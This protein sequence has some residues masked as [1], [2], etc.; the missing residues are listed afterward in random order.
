VAK[1]NHFAAKRG[2]MEEIERRRTEALARSRRG[3]REGE[4]R[5]PRLSLRVPQLALVNLGAGPG[6]Q[7]RLDHLTED[8][9]RDSDGRGLGRRLRPV[10]VPLDDTRP[11]DERLADLAGRQF[12][13][14]HSG[15]MAGSSTAFRNASAAC[16]RAPSWSRISAQTT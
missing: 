3:G 10:V 2:Q 15:V 4:A 7:D 1:Y 14:L 5:L 13:A 11:P 9:V 8:L 6:Y 16:S 12:V